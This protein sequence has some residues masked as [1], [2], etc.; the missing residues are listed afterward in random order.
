MKDLEIEEKKATLHL[1]FV[2]KSEKEKRDVLRLYESCQ[3]QVEDLEKDNERLRASITAQDTM[4]EEGR[5][6]KARCVEVEKSL[7]A[8]NAKLQ[9]LGALKYMIF[10]RPSAWRSSSFPGGFEFDEARASEIFSWLA[11]HATDLGI[12]SRTFGGIGANVALRVVLGDAFRL[13]GD[14]VNQ[15]LDLRNPH[16][17]WPSV[18]DYANTHAGIAS[19]FIKSFWKTRGEQ[20]AVS[21]AERLSLKALATSGLLPSQL[22]TGSNDLGSS[23]RQAEHDAREGTSRGSEP[24]GRDSDGRD[25]TE[26]QVLEYGPALVIEDVTPIMMK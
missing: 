2:K 4:L 12:A 15:L 16:R 18:E 10:G 1:C 13:L 3:M 6:A 8:N 9:E 24:D 5:N 17:S 20:I 14:D 23:S 26:D 25:A 22:P 21:E 7:V 11:G 19:N